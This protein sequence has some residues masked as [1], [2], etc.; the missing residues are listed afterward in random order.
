MRDYYLRELENELSVSAGNIRRELLGLVSSGLF[1][2]YKRGRLLYYK[3]HADSSMF[4]AVTMLMSPKV[5]RAD[6]I[7]KEGFI[8]TTMPT[9]QK[10]S[11]DYYCQTR[12]TYGARL[13]SFGL[14]LEE[15]V[16]TDAYLITAI[17]G[18][19]GNNSFDHNLGNW[20][21][22]PGVFF[23][24]DDKRNIIVISDR[25]QGIFKTI[26]RVKKDV[27]NDTEALTVAFT[28]TISGR[29]PE[30]RGNGLKF[31]TQI[32]KDKKWNLVFDSGRACLRIGTDGRIKI[33]EGKRNIHGCFAVITW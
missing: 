25:G 11:Q 19:I 23:A 6:D 3:I 22:A 29:W 24:H 1:V 26:S 14:H 27:K 20:P 15:N 8:W 4:H 32:I 33:R 30:K 18:E 28:Q 17:A 2:T 31:V 10:I 13:Q 7:Q 5:Q 9:P 21:D 12:D 16:G